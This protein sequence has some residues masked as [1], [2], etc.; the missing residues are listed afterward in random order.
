MGG[1]TPTATFI[2]IKEKPQKR[3][4]SIIEIKA[5]RRSVMIHIVHFPGFDKY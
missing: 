4:H 5:R 2:E 3:T 1:N